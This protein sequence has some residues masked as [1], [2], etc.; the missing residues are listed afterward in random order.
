MIVC[1]WAWDKDY[2]RYMLRAMRCTPYEAI[3]IVAHPAI[4]R[5]LPR[6]YM[7]D[8]QRLECW[9][10]LQYARSSFS[11]NQTIDWIEEEVL[12]AHEAI[13]HDWSG[14]LDALVAAKD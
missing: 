2:R 11:A 7:P 3:Q 6:L 4:D 14:Y 12:S 1:D 10:L 5:S 13:T 9:F 8:K